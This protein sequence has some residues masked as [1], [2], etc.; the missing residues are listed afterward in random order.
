MPESAFLDTSTQIA[1]HFEQKGIR[2]AIEKELAGR[3]LHCSAYVL[4]EYKRTLVNSC[5]ALHNL[6]LNSKDLNEALERSEYFQQNQ[7]SLVALSERV[8][9]R[10]GLIARLPEAI[11]RR[12]RNIAETFLTFGVDR[13]EE[14][15]LR[16]NCQTTNRWHALLP[17]KKRA[18]VNG[19]RRNSSNKRG[20]Q[21]VKSATLSD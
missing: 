12:P 1:R 17:N 6:L 14:S 8:R 20:M 9:R 3:G 21:S 18:R 7:V 15:V 5:V 4:Q 19:L 11:W 10:I 13:L 16:K 2:T